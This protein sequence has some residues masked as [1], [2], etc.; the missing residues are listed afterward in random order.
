[1]V[2]TALVVS[3]TFSDWNVL[4]CSSLSLAWNSSFMSYEALIV[5]IF[6]TER[7]MSNYCKKC[8]KWLVGPSNDSQSLFYSRWEGGAA[9]K[10]DL[11]YATKIIS[12]TCGLHESSQKNFVLLNS[13]IS[14][15]LDMQTGSTN[16]N[17]SSRQVF[18][19]FSV[20][21]KDVS[22]SYDMIVST[23]ESFQGDKVLEKK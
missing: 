14:P 10:T 7:S 2:K 19:C 8:R 18:W 1:M 20:I 11:I 16:S 21:D 12:V 4:S 23:H 5:K 13:N 9:V 17:S 15:P 3:N 6:W 22:Q